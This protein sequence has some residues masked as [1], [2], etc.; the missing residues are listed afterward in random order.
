[1][2]VFLVVTLC[3]LVGRYERFGGTHCLHLQ[4]LSERGGRVV[5]SPASVFG[6][7]W[8]QIS[9]RVPDVLTESVRGFSRSLQ[10]NAG[11]VP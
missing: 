4:G 8:V 1:M 9:A 7:T 5:S 3:G 11:I 6:R 2:L 10:E